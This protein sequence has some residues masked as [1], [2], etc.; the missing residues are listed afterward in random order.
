MCVCVCVCV[1]ER[2]RDYVCIPFCTEAVD[3]HV[4]NIFVI[5]FF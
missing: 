1:R 4:F 3:E 2:E 5:F